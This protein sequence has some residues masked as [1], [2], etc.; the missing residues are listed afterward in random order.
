MSFG[1]WGCCSELTEHECCVPACGKCCK[2]PRGDHKKKK[3][4]S[5]KVENHHC[6]CCCQWSRKVHSPFQQSDGPPANAREIIVIQQHGPAGRQLIFKTQPEWEN[7][8]LLNCEKWVVCFLQTGWFFTFFF[9]VAQATVVSF[10]LSYCAQAFLAGGLDWYQCH[11]PKP[12]T[13]FDLQCCEMK[14][15]PFLALSGHLKSSTALPERSSV[16]KLSRGLSV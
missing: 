11:I 6:T 14:I 9:L 13:S 5:I 15:K 4:K 3:K 16:H 8:P 10:D 1:P 7:Q 2:H 12:G